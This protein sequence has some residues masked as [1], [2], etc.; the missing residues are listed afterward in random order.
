M[1]FIT[2]YQSLDKTDR[3]LIN[4]HLDTLNAYIDVLLSSPKYERRNRI[5]I[6]T[7]ERTAN[8]A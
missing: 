5:K 3:E 1:D 6:T 8:N 7:N 4:E 2:K